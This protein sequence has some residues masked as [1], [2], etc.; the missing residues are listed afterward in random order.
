VQDSLP[1]TDLHRVGQTL[2]G[3]SGGVVDLRNIDQEL[4]AVFL[5]QRR[6][7]PLPSEVSQLPQAVLP[8]DSTL[9]LEDTLDV[10]HLTKDLLTYQLPDLDR[11]TGELHYRE[12]AYDVNTRMNSVGLGFADPFYHLPKK[13][14]HP[15]PPSSLT[16]S[17]TL[18]SPSAP[19]LACSRAC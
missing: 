15:L 4:A 6:R 8:L 3:E 18:P 11:P 9:L 16:R 17:S 13:T 2:G 7:P 10:A 19:G 14:S 12:V 1:I 5:V